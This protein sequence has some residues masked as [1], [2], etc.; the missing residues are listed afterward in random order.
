MKKKVKIIFH[1]DMNAFFISCELINHPELKNKPLAIA[2]RAAIY[3]KGVVVTA[4]YEAR[5]FG[6]KAAGL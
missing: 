3:N 2:G 5:K 4:S 1:I 6:V